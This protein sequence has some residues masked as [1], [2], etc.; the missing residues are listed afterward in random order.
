[1]ASF[2]LT[3][4]SA[5]SGK[6]TCAPETFAIHVGDVFREDRNLLESHSSIG[7]FRPPLEGAKSSFHRS[8]IIWGVAVGPGGTCRFRAEFALNEII[9]WPQRKLDWTD[10]RCRDRQF[11]PSAAPSCAVQ[12]NEGQRGS[13]GAVSRGPEYDLQGLG[14]WG[15]SP[16]PC[17]QSGRSP[18][19]SPTSG[20]ASAVALRHPGWAGRRQRHLPCQVSLEILG[21]LPT[22]AY[23]FAGSVSIPLSGRSLPGAAK[24]RD[25][26]E[27]EGISA[28]NPPH[29][30]AETSLEGHRPDSSSYRATLRE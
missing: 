18:E 2:R 23:R 26:A 24:R 11:P 27:A 13:R 10:G 6:I 20:F 5:A 8:R 7:V 15:T 17:S 14:G 29:E 25:R 3:G 12:R 28:G 30:L 21:Q 22:V 9:S 1:M 4:E 19:K 16:R